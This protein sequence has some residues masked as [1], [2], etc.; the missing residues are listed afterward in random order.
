MGVPRF[1]F[2][3]YTTP[4]YRIGQHVHCERFG[5]VVI[6][7][8][9]NGRIAWPVARRPGARG[10]ASLVL[11]G[12]L[13]RAV[14]QETGLAI[15]Y[16]FG[17]GTSAVDFMRKALD[18][19]QVN[20]GTLTRMRELTNLPAFKA[21]QLKAW[22]KARDPERRRKIAE[23]RRGVKRSPVTV[24]KIAASLRGKRRSTAAKQ[25]HSETNRAR[26][27]RP[28][29]LQPAWSEAEYEMLRTLPAVKVAKRTG[30]TLSAVYSQR[31]ILGLPDARRRS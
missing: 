22:S 31:S 29:W 20:P 24:E 3:P 9:S 23:A 28:P 2:G 6:V 26:G 27:I 8:T 15:K 4:R 1:Y 25:K 5:D 21:M 13:A 11:Y 7:G 30:R 16:W 17:A 18:V 14:R 19:P 12:D 10:R